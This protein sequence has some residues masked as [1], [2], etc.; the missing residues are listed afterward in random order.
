MGVRNC[1]ELGENLQ[2]IV[3]RLL[4]NDKLVNL[5]YY[6]DKEPLSH[7]NLTDEQK[8][9][10]VF[11]KLIKIIPRVGPKEDARSVV[12]VRVAKANKIPGNTEFKNVR[13]EIETVVPFTQWL[14]KDTN[15]RPF[16]ILG[17]IEKSLDG[18]VINGLGK[19]FGGDLEANFYTEEAGVFLQ[20][21][22]ITSYE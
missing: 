14:I 8:R 11:E 7:T 13:I 4:A 5:L 18:K 19:M 9:E 21:F 22:Y 10:L 1:A 16:L 12:I 6:T 17:E 2:I 20:T 3:S 15:L